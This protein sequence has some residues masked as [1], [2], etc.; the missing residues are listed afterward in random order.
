MRTASTPRFHSLDLADDFVAGRATSNAIHL[1]DAPEAMAIGALVVGAGSLHS[2]HPFLI[3]HWAAHFKLSNLN[4]SRWPGSSP[5]GVIKKNEK[6][7][8]AQPQNSHFSG[9]P[10]SSGAGGMVGSDLYVD[11]LC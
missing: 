10:C 3:A 8:R 11:K 5:S 1:H 7:A 6:P 4:V 9:G 2:G